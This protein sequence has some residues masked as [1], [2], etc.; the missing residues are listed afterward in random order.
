VPQLQALRYGTMRVYFMTLDGAGRTGA[1]NPMTKLKVRQAISMAIDRETLAKQLIQGDSHVIDTP[2]FPTQFGCDVSAAVKYPYDPAKAKQLLTEAGYP[3]GFDTEVVSPNSNPAQLGAAVQNYLKAIG[4]NLR[5]QQLQIGAAIQ[6]MEAGK[7]PLYASSW[8]SN[9]I[10]DASAFMPYFLGGGL[11]DYA[12]DA[13]VQNLLKQAA[14]SADPEQR[15]KA[16]SEAIHL[17][18]ERADIMPMFS[19]VKNVAFSKQ[20][21]F[22]GF[23][24]DLPRFYMSS[25]K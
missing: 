19:D 6:L 16:Y 15:R 20:L 7:A 2:C 12:R 18:T 24:D 14:A 25:W 21:N 9:S 22:E 1:D 3:N 11:D 8:G 4:I 17:A 5:I 23:P 13:D 10:N